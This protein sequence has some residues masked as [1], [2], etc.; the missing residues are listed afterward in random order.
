MAGRI[1]YGL[2]PGVAIL[3]AAFGQGMQTSRAKK[4]R[5]GIAQPNRRMAQHLKREL[6]L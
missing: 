1:T 4:Q 6:S 2:I 5:I 3:L